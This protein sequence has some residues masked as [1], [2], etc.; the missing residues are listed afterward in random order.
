M[1][2]TFWSIALTSATTFTISESFLAA[3]VCNLN[4]WDKNIFTGKVRNV[5]N[6]NSLGEWKG[7]WLK[8]RFLGGKY[9]KFQETSSL[10]GG[11]PDQFTSSIGN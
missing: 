7:E 4:A 1:F 9:L 10:E 5:E 2:V 8:L 3:E 6:P 11:V